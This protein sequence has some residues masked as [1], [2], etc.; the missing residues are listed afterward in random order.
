MALL[1]VLR[2]VDEVK[3][4]AASSETEDSDDELSLRDFSGHGVGHAVLSL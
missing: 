1:S 2:D 3:H 4:M